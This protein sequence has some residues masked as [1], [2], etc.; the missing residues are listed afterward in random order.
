MRTLSARPRAT[1]TRGRRQAESY[2]GQFTRL[3]IILLISG[4]ALTVATVL[5][6]PESIPRNVL[7]IGASLVALV[8]LLVAATRMPPSVRAVWWGLFAYQVLAVLADWI[9]DIQHAIHEPAASLQVA[10]AVFIAAYLPV[11]FVL[12]VLVRR[13]HPGRNREA[14]IDTLI[15]AA[16]A[17]AV[18]G[19]FLIAPAVSESQASGLG[20]VLAVAFPLF[21]LL[22]VCALVWLIASTG[23]LNPAL[24]LITGSFLLY[25]AGD[26]L[27]DVSLSEGF[28]DQSWALYEGLHLGALVLMAAAATGPGARS[29]AAADIDPDIR[30][31]PLR[32]LALAVGVV[33]IPAILVF[34]LVG[35]VDA[36]TVALA[37]ASAVI[38]LLTIWRIALLVGVVEGQSRLTALVLDSAADGIVGLDDDGFVLFANL[39]ARRMLRCRESDLVGYRFHDIAHHHHPDGREYPWQDC[40]AGALLKSGEM[41]AVEGQHYFRRDGSSFPVEIVV[42]PLVLDGVHRGSVTSFRDVTERQAIA[43]VQRQ[44]VSIVSHELRTPLTSIKGSLQMLDSGLFGELSQDQQELVSMAVNNSDRL[45]RLVNDILDLERLDSGR[46]P[47]APQQVDAADLVEQSLAVVRGV[48]TTAGVELQCEK[49]SDDVD[50]DLFV[51]P[52]RL[53]QVLVNLIGNAVKFS[54]RGSQVRTVV[55]RADDRITINVVDH[56]RGI[57]EDQLQR[58]FDRFGQV[59]VGDAREHGGTGLG[60]AIAKEIVERS[61]GTIIVTSQLGQGSTFSVELPAA[62]VEFAARVRSD[63]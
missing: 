15:L 38:I 20:L 59:E 7:Y 8:V 54:E 11:I 62:H 37:V 46:M 63:A 42:T 56:G 36:V 31:T 19:A 14:W 13:V 9:M 57:P 40:P 55:T 58:V 28:T 23:R 4:L 25:L 10:D 52:H 12:V 24:V 5:L 22:I 18:V 3:W 30:A 32:I 50:L 44:F 16:A 39:S 48:A 51:D 26:V 17:A 6:P 53:G 43:E 29:I 61:G 2:R 33:T 47:M 1:R 34:R 41:G 21:D 60:L 45:A 35:D 27:R 49:P